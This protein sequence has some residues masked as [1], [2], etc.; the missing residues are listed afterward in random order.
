MTENLEVR[1]YLMQ[2]F[3]EFNMENFSDHTAHF[4]SGAK[5]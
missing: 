4:G 1:A 5:N 3:M 2:N